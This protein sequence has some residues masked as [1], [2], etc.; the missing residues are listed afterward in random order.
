MQ[1]Q[2]KII[3]IISMENTG[4]SSKQPDHGSINYK[5]KKHG[6]ELCRAF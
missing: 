6:A 1:S 4:Q 3:S 5:F 2:N